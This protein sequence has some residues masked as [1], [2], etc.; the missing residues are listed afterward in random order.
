MNIYRE[1]DRT[2]FQ[3]DFV[4]HTNEKCIFTE[5]VL[6]LGGRIYSCPSYKGVNHIEYCR[7]WNAFLKK[8][9]FALIH[10]HV[11][12]T[13]SIYLKI[14]KKH[15]VK[16]ISHSHST[17]SGSN[18]KGMVKNFLQY[19][20]RFTSD[21]FLAC[22]KD[23]GSWLFGK[24]IIDSPKFSIINNAINTESFIFNEDIRRELR[25]RYGINDR[26]VVGHIGRFTKEKNHE[27]ILG[28]YHELYKL[29]EKSMLVLVG[30]G[31]EQEYIKKLVEKLK[32]SENV[33]FMG[34]KTNVADL[35]QMF[36]VFLFPSLWE[37][38]GMAVIEAEA[39][40]LECVVSSEVPKEVDITNLVH[41][42]DLKTENSI[43][44]KKVLDIGT[45]YI[46]RNMQK[47]IRANNYDV[48]VT[49]DWIE[50]YYNKV[51]NS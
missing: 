45:G 11:R 14:A 24:K 7:W 4:I 27:K 48:Q 28:I 34:A 16:T 47:E 44:A 33:L 9:S 43:W 36:D 30:E 3:F 8:K 6:S 35:L 17:A 21:Y 23:A 29:D 50:K 26:L 22:S 2:K 49:T 42:I 15:K 18:I 46:R 13:A 37:G 25:I 38:L 39:S 5:E 1:I 19:P 12:S 51:I 32:L 31:D 10:G 40:G 20:I 41:F